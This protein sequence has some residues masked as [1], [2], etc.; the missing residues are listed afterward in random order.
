MDVIADI[1]ATLIAQFQKPTLAFLMGGML[2]AALG[3]KLEVPAPIYK[4]IVLLLLLKV[5]LG[6]G[7]SVRSADAVSLAIPA[8]CAVAVGVLIVVFGGKILSMWQ[9]ISRSDAM[10]TAGLFGAVSASTLAAGMAMLDAEGIYYE[11]FIGALYPFMDVAALVTAIFLARMSE[12]RA[13][14]V[15]IQGGTATLSSGDGFSGGG[16]SG[17]SG[18][19]FGMAKGIITDTMKSPAISALLLGIG[20]GLLARPEAIYESFYEPLFRGLLSILMLIMGMEAWSRLSELKKVAHAYLIY[21]LAAP[22]LHGL[23]GFGFGM[24]AHHLTGFSAGGVVLL[25]LMAA[26]SSD[27]SGPPTMRAALP[28][29][30][31][32]AYI[33]A[34]TGLGTP[35]AILSIPMFIALADWLIG[36]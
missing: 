33:G 16:F 29:A 21:A 18:F 26:S 24:I 8:L 30:N 23:L 34:S 7:I 14:A 13:D 31:P 3:S 19:D 1:A 20:I 32:S 25:A 28:E 5:G 9:G 17:G 36:F 27:I 6:A 15:N 22:I 4:F 35:V 2:L 11:G 12:A 10:A